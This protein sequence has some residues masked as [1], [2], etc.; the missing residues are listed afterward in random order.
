MIFCYSQSVENMIQKLNEVY[1]AT[2]GTDNW[3]TV[4]NM[5]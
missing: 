5:K 1:E 4:G 3:T 2:E